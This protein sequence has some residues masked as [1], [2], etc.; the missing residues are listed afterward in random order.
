MG[1][2]HKNIRLPAAR[3]NGEQ[4]YFVTLCCAARRRVFA[5]AERASGIVGELRQ[6]AAAHGFAVY[7]YCVMPDHLHLL[8]IGLSA[9]SDLLAFLKSLKQKTAYEFRQKFGRD[10]WQK[11]DLGTTKTPLNADVQGH[12]VLLV[13]LEKN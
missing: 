9:T 3:Y 8:V 5:D 4:R 11:K 10:L 2:P 6:Q 1:F 12:D 7:A 13:R